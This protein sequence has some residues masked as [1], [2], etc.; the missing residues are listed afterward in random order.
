MVNA[1]TLK[2]LPSIKSPVWLKD[3][4][5]ITPNKKLLGRSLMILLLSLSLRIGFDTPVAPL[6][7][8]AT[9]DTNSLLESLPDTVDQEVMSTMLNESVTSDRYELFTSL[10]TDAQTALENGDYCIY[11]RTKLLQAQ[12]ILEG[13]VLAD[14]DYWRAL[15]ILQRASSV[16]PFD[17]EI[18][19]LIVET[20]QKLGIDSSLRELYLEDAE[21]IV[22]ACEQ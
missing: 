12:I 3:L 13:E 17:E 20:M 16:N 14:E 11:S 22:S 19:R 2:V 8:N 7:V 18:Q 1:H 15:G 5:P 10:E 6:V 9:T 21:E 4:W